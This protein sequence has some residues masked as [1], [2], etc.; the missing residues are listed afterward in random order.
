MRAAPTWLSPLSTGSGT[1]MSGELEISGDIC[2][3]AIIAAQAQPEPAGSSQ[4]MTT[5]LTKVYASPE[6]SYAITDILMARENL[7]VLGRGATSRWLAVA[8]SSMADLK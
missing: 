6:C 1:S 5:V 3:A 7:Q 2:P 4:A 8:V